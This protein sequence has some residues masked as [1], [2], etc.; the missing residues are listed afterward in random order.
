MS[1]LT[2]L[3]SSDKAIEKFNKCIRRAK[4]NFVFP[5]YQAVCVGTP[6]IKEQNAVMGII[7]EVR[8]GYQAEQ[9]R[10]K[11]KRVTRLVN[12][13]EVIKSTKYIYIMQKKCNL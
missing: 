13:L 8:K 10:F 9:D 11:E 5:T 12:I 2:I 4:A 3:A 1:G 6:K 7:M